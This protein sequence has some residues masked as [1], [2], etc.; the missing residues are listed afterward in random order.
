M[1]HDQPTIETSI[2]VDGETGKL[3]FLTVLVGKVKL[4]YH[5]GVTKLMQRKSSVGLYTL[6]Q[7]KHVEQ[8]SDI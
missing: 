5:I 1:V 7:V 2:T 6:V 3:Q 4:C 8:C